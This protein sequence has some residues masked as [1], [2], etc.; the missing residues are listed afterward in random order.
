MQFFQNLLQTMFM[1]NSLLQWISAA[2]V[3]ALVLLAQRL[4]QQIVVQRV[5]RLT[6][7]TRTLCLSLLAQVAR[8]C[9]RRTRPSPAA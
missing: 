6:E 5:R 4:L 3:I 9:R 2:L 8:G 1:N 7:R